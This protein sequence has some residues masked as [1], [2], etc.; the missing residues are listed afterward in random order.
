[1]A[2]RRPRTI[3][4]MRDV[5]TSPKAEL[6]LHL[7]GAMRVDTVRELAARNGITP[8]SGLGPEG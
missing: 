6:P 8:P 3:P 4:A 5:R 7:E 2:R 1:M